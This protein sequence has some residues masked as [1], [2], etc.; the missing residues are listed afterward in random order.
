MLYRN[1]K[2][3]FITNLFGNWQEVGAQGQLVP[4]GGLIYYITS[5]RTL[6]EALRDPV[7]TVIYVL[8]IVGSCALFSRTWIE[9]SGQ[10]PK[11]VANQLKEQK[12]FLKGYSDEATYQKLKKLIMTAATLGGI[13]IG[14]LTIFADFLGAIGSGTGILLTVSIIYSLYEEMVKNKVKNKRR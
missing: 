7:H 10:G 1:F 5:P 6:F 3:S 4:V 8:F 2:G 14:L 9:V 11:E 13:C 12:M